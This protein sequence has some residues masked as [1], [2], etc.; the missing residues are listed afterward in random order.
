MSFPKLP[1]EALV[2]MFIEMCA[3]LL[4][5]ENLTPDKQT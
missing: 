4:T 2:Q 3:W 5:P 1:D